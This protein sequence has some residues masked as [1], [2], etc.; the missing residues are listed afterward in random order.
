MLK[1]K[2]WFWIKATPKQLPGKTHSARLQIS[3]DVI[4]LSVFSQ[5]FAAL[6]VSDVFPKWVGNTVELHFVVTTEFT[7]DW[8]NFSI[9]VVSEVNRSNWYFFCHHDWPRDGQKHSVNQTHL[10]LGVALTHV[11]LWLVKS[12]EKQNS[13]LRLRWN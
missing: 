8:P 12:D 11:W 5:W 6:L 13:F 10:I 1:L 4:F 3:W 2:L 7:W 9:R